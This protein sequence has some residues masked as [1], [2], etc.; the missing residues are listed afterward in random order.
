VSPSGK[1]SRHDFII[2]QKDPQ[3]LY[4]IKTVL[5]FGSVKRYANNKQGTFH[6][7]YVVSDIDGIFK[8]MQ[9]FNGRLILTKTRLRYTEC[10]KSF[11]TRPDVILK[12]YT[13]DFIEP[14]CQCSLKDAWLSGFVDADGCFNAT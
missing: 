9:I 2:T 10:F 8:L 6:Y 5:G 3:V 7:R 11:F 12:G 14:T 13:L 1:S 4:K